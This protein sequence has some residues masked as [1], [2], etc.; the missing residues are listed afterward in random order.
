MAHAEAMAL[1][2][3]SIGFTSAPA[4]NELIKDGINGLLCKDSVKDYAQG[5]AK[6]MDNQSMRCLMGQQAKQMTK[7]Y[8][9][10]VVWNKWENLFLKL[11][12]KR[13]NPI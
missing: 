10:N 6:L 3:P 1:G 13:T 4:V 2:L 8:A 5:L 9:P 7:A 12:E 11:I